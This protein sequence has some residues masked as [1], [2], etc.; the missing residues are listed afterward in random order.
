MKQHDDY[1]EEEHGSG[2]K[3]TYVYMALIRLSKQS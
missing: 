1:Y 3:I 2:S